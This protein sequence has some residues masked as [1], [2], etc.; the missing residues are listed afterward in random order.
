[1]GFIKFMASTAGRIARF[2]IGAAVFGFGMASAN[3]WLIGLGVFFMVV[4]LFDVCV[5]APLF[6]LPVSGKAIRSK[7]Q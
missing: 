7:L 2:V 1:M 4:G 3:F 5:L 6:K